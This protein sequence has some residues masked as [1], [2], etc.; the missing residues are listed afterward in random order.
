VYVRLLHSRGGAFFR[1]WGAQNMIRVAIL[2]DGGSLRVRTQQAGRGHVPDHIEKV[3]LACRAADEQIIRILYYDCAPYVGRAKLPV[4]GTFRSFSGS[5]AWLRELA[6]KDLFAVRRGILKFRGFV[7]K[8]IPL[9]TTLL[10]DADFKPSFEQKGV[11]MRI[12]LDIA[13]CSNAR[14]V[15]RIVLITEDT[16]CV[17]AMK[18]ARKTGLQ[19]V[20]IS[21]P[22]SH[23]A[24]ELKEHCDFERAVSWP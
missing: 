4:S 18:H 16:D 23:L 11:D 12:G 17:P 9:S 21:L 2:I 13:Q 15:E 8:S 10:T 5:D 7:P 6:R 3:A 20:L 24:P 1:L 22:T 19:V 14:A